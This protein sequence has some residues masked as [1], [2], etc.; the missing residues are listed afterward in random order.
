MDT[1]GHFFVGLLTVRGQ[2]KDKYHDH[3]SPTKTQ[4]IK[5]NLPLTLTWKRWDL[6]PVWPGGNLDLNHLSFLKKNF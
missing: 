1:I 4:Y 2:I 3:L 6:N 5:K